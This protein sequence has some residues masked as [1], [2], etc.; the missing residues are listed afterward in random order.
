MKWKEC[1]GSAVII[2]DR[3]NGMTDH[4]GKLLRITPGEKIVLETE[5]HDL[6]DIRIGK[7]DH[8]EWSPSYRR[9]DV[10][11]ITK[12][13]KEKRMTVGPVGVTG[14]KALMEILEDAKAV[15]FDQLA[16]MVLG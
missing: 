13:V 5:N 15:E 2:V 9:T 7:D 3:R 11:V 1:C 12:E 14:M 16:K 6:V 10:L 8:L 4:V